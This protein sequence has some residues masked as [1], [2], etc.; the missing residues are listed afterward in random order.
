MFW[1]VGMDVG[2]TPWSMNVYRSQV[3]NRRDAI[4]YALDIAEKIYPDQR[5]SFNF[6]K[7]YDNE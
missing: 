7:E 5:I 3:T 6:V 2:S 1:E 4:E